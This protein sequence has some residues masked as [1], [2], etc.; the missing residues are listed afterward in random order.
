MSGGKKRLQEQEIGNR[1]SKSPRTESIWI[2][3]AIIINQNIPTEQAREIFLDPNT[4]IL[5][6]VSLEGYIRTIESHG[7]QQEEIISLTTKLDN[8]LKAYENLFPSAIN[9]DL[10]N[11]I[12]GL[13][14][15]LETKLP[16]EKHRKKS[17]LYMARDTSSAT[18]STSSTF[19][20]ADEP[21]HLSKNSGLQFQN[22]IRTYNNSYR[23]FYNILPKTVDFEKLLTK[24]NS[25]MGV[26]INVFESESYFEQF[27]D[28][29][30]ELDDITKDLIWCF[31][32]IEKEIGQI[33]INTI[34]A[35]EIAEKNINLKGI[36]NQ[37]FK[38]SIPKG[39]PLWLFPENV[40]QKINDTVSTVIKEELKNRKQSMKN[41]FEQITLRGG[42]LLKV[43]YNWC[44]NANAKK[45]IEAIVYTVKQITNNNI[46]AIPKTTNVSVQSEYLKLKGTSSPSTQISDTLPELKSFKL[47]KNLQQGGKR[48]VN[49][50]HKQDN[51]ESEYKPRF[52]KRQPPRSNQGGKRPK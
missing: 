12:E 19:A 34:K 29:T 40:V 27:K 25:H 42:D 33:Y 38:F 16:P 11:A 24:S 36:Y 14:T 6:F 18:T 1:E 17:V 4:E 13:Y 45:A 15:Q 20:M 35:V 51:N 26:D 9:K 8:A 10:I 32:Y 2:K 31:Y 46:A 50:Q 39:V 21:E 7:F 47:K 48:R 41:T 43:I 23:N 44:Q 5:S 28:M 3:A 49:N 52:K 37:Y 30:K 22:E